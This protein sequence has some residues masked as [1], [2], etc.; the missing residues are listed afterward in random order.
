MPDNKCAVQQDDFAKVYSMIAEAQYNTWRHINKTLID[1][2]W[3]IGRFIS[4]RVSRN[5]WGK[6]IV[7]DMAKYI[8]TQNPS[9]T[10]FSARNLWRMK[11]FYE[12]YRGD[13]K[14]SALLT[15]FPTP[16]RGMFTD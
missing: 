2:Y 11:Q 7:E 12:A 5:V 15:E 16:T 4:E 8:S 13:I 6:R 10:G 3:N 1:L 9:I 14:L